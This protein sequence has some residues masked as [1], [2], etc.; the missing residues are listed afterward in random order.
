[1][2]EHVSIASAQD[3]LAAR[4]GGKDV[5]AWRSPIPF[6]ISRILCGDGRT[7]VV[8]THGTVGPAGHV[9][10]QHSSLV[11]MMTMDGRPYHP[12]TTQD[13]RHGYPPMSASSPHK[14]VTNMAPLWSPT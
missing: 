10:R 6:S 12:T 4:T 8:G 13:V 9:T 1:M 11:S 5:C 7:P 14:S 2:R 3:S